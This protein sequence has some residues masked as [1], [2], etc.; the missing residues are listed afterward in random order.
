M[1]YLHF[2]ELM[3]NF[4]HNTSLTSF[5]CK[6]L[7][8]KAFLLIQLPHT[9]P[10][11]SKISF[12]KRCFWPLQHHQCPSLQTNTWH[13]KILYFVGDLSI[14][15]TRLVDKI[16]AVND[17]FTD[18]GKNLCWHVHVEELLISIL[19]RD[20]ELNITIQDTVRPTRFARQDIIYSYPV[21]P[22]NTYM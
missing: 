14:R 22:I 16:C 4:T 13:L 3:W 1:V 6:I 21:M 11:N 20:I 19:Y 8:Q 9:S 7:I 10:M 12:L 18:G 2:L 5:G 15:F 17:V